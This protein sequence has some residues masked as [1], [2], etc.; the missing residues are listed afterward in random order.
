MKKLLLPI[1]SLL[2]FFG[3]SPTEENGSEGASTFEMSGIVENADSLQVKL[4]KRID[5]EWV[6]EDSVLIVDKGFTLTGNIGLPE[7]FY[8]SIGNG[9]SYVRVFAEAAAKINIT[10][11]ADSLNKA[12]VTGSSIHDKFEVYND[13]LK[14]YNTKIKALYPQYELADSLS[15]KEMEAKLDSIYEVI[16]DEKSA[17]TKSIILE[18]LTNPLAPYLTNSIYYDDSKLEEMTALVDKF[19]T[20][21]DSSLYTI[22]LKKMM[23]I[24]KKTAVG[25]IAIDFSQNDTTGTSV[26]L[27]SLRGQYVL[28]DFWASWC[29]PCRAENPNVV[30][31]YNEL[32]D[33]GFEIIGV[34][35]DTKRKNWLKAIGDDKLS[36]YQV[37][38]L[39]GW[40]NEVGG[41]YSVRSIPHTILLDKDGVIIAKN[42]R[43]EE[44]REKLEELLL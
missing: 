26:T 24:W 1:L 23:D 30:K 9:K 38:D 20:A 21:I 22:K 29:G 35:F 10:A 14:S 44:L 15:D 13:G 5:G 17:Y 2:V 39:K 43:G 11:N 4:Q 6:V 42:L 18:N 32:H 7:L 16:A 8:L 12:T 41:L 37:S 19:D 3:C 40:K 34:S 25:Q 36:W 28:I 33:K 31:L 27:S